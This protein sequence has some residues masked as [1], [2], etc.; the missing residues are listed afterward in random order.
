MITPKSDKLFVTGSTSPS[1]FS[2][3]LVL[4]ID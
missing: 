4:A 2:T 3:F 1:T